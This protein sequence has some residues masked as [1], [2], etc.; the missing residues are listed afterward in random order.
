MHPRR[1]ERCYRQQRFEQ[2]N[3]F[4][5]VRR[6]QRNIRVDGSSGSA[7][8]GLLRCG[9]Q[10]RGVPVKNNFQLIA[11]VFNGT[12]SGNGK[13][14]PVYAKTRQRIWMVIHVADFANF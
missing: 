1:P 6:S 14:V 11:I 3:E 9:G 8:R 5:I 2:M 4:T 7:Q 10:V 13:R 12:T